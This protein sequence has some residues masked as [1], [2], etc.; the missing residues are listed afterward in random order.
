[1][2][3]ADAKPRHQ[4]EA[5]ANTSRAA[6]VPP[7]PLDVDAA[8]AE[9][10][11]EVG[12]V[13]RAWCEGREPAPLTVC[14]HPPGLGKTRASLGAVLD[15]VCG[16]EG[17][18]SRGCLVVWVGRGRPAVEAVIRHAHASGRASAEQALYVLGREAMKGAP[19]GVQ[20]WG[21]LRGGVATCDN[22]TALGAARRGVALRG[23]C[24]RGA[25]AS[26]PRC[27]AA[28]WSYGTAGG[29]ARLRDTVKRA[30]RGPS[31]LVATVPTLAPLVWD[32]IQRARRAG[33]AARVLWVWDDV[34]PSALTVVRAEA[35]AVLGVLG[36]GPGV[37]R[38]VRAVEAAR[39][40]AREAP[41]GVRAELPPLDAE[42]R[43][44][45]AGVVRLE[46]SEA[47]VAAGVAYGRPVGEVLRA[48]AAGLEV[49]VL[50]SVDKKGA[51]AV[52]LVHRPRQDWTGSGEHLVLSSTDAPSLWGFLGM[53]EA[54][55]LGAGLLARHAAR[56]EVLAHEDA[57]GRTRLARLDA[58]EAAGVA[59]TLA[60]M[61]GER[62][63]ARAGELLRSEG[64]PLR[65]L[66]LG[67]RKFVEREG[68]CKAFGEQLARE[69]GEAV[70][71]RAVHWGAVEAT[72]SN[73][74][75][76]WGAVAA[77]ALP[78]SNPHAVH[79]A[80]GLSRAEVEADPER[81]QA[82]ESEWAAGELL[83]GV[84]RL[85]LWTRRGVEVAVVVGSGG[86]V[87]R[88]L[89]GLDGE[90]LELV[91]LEAVPN[92]VRPASG[93][94]L[95]S[96]RCELVASLAGWPAW[97]GALDRL[98]RIP[99]ARLA[100]FLAEPSNLPPA[101]T[102]ARRAL[103]PRRGRAP[104]W[105]GPS[106]GAIREAVARWFSEVEGEP[107]D[108]ARLRLLP[109]NAEAERS[110]D[111]S[112]A[113]LVPSRPSEV[114]AEVVALAEGSEALRELWREA[115]EA[116]GRAR[117]RF[118]VGSKVLA[119]AEAEGEA[120]GARWAPVDVMTLAWVARRA[121]VDVGALASVARGE[122]R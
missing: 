34:Q 59:R 42:A 94:P 21:A 103:T 88:A 51:V 75:L 100:R 61:W 27:M 96:T 65:V 43:K 52:E 57:A 95:R 106:E 2:T 30:G 10:E 9:V 29:L 97:S 48:L 80:H 14:A 26:A 92:V 118:L 47:E 18:G 98:A 36:G 101:W 63:R 85:R 72:G 89:L 16:A 111:T 67:P 39:E 13:V 8:R 3:R 64:E 84:A 114:E 93:Q 82:L 17:E 73:D 40:L 25:C 76:T 20:P 116:V 58:S 105:Y 104:V 107:L 122:G 35:A 69:L 7:C 55:V 90:P 71:V 81:A 86:G 87:P 119:L 91:P 12:G 37:G 99:S 1:M 74:F 56:V 15:V 68:V 109:L 53:G 112:R 110:A 44:A 49:E 5:H 102:V 32:E 62:L 4:R 115:G 6:L 113:A 31:A 50:A 117:L 54:E 70:E 60:R 79:L 78:R 108:P 38:L 28:G 33:E 19:L 121:P 22:P 11:A 83:Q 46:W 45:L 77:L 24:G 120:V 41:A 23:V 66:V